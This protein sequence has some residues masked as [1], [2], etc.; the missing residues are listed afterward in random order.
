MPGG[1]RGRRIHVHAGDWKKSVHSWQKWY[2]LPDSMNGWYKRSIYLSF[3]LCLTSFRDWK[4]FKFILK[5]LHTTWNTSWFW[6]QLCLLPTHSV[7]ACLACLVLQS[8]KLVSKIGN[9]HNETALMSL[10]FQPNWIKI[11][12]CRNSSH[13]SPNH[14]LFH[15]QLLFNNKVSYLYVTF[16][17]IFSTISTHLM[18]L[19]C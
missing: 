1:H 8:P 2:S 11:D 16:T 3:A 14:I 12:S 6:A 4:N 10:P 7:S 9:L 19:F 5:T 13:V 18:W 15:L 17:F